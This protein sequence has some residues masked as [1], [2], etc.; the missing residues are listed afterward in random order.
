MRWAFGQRKKRYPFHVVPL[1][2]QVTEDTVNNGLMAIYYGARD[3]EDY[4]VYLQEITL[5]FKDEELREHKFF[6]AIYRL[7]RRL[8]Y[9]RIV[10]VET[11]D[12]LQNSL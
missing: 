6:D 11:L 1:I 5:V 8:L 4:G 9:G 7:I 2:S 12:F 10:D 3:F